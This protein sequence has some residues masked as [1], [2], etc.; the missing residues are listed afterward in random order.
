MLTTFRNSLFVLVT[1][2][3][4][5][6]GSNANDWRA[7][8]VGRVVA[9]ADVHGAYDAMVETL[10]NVGILD[11]QLAW[12][13]GDAYL[14]IVGDLLDRGPRSRDALDLLMRLENEAE[15]AGG[16]VQVLIGNHESMNLIGDLRYVSK[17]EY[18]AFADEETKEQRDYWLRAWES[19]VGGSRLD[20]RRR[21][22]NSFP[23]GFFAL[24]KAFSPE[25]VYGKWL[26]QKNVVAVVNRTAFVHGGLPPEVADLGLEGVNG[27]LKQDLVD[28][29]NAVSILTKAKVLLPMDAFYDHEEIVQ[30]YL[31]PLDT[32][33]EVL[34]AMAT[35]KRLGD[36]AVLH[37]DGPL[38]YRGNIACS[39]IIEEH[40]LQASLD[41]IGA[42][43][44]VVGHTP[45]PTRKVLQRF[46]GRVIEVDTGMLNTYYKGSGN[47]LVM[48]GDEL[49]VFNQ[50]GTDAYAPI[51]HPR[52]VG[53]RPGNLSADALQQLLATGE[54]ISRAKEDKAGR[55]LVQVSDNTHTVSAI[56][57]KR[58]GKGF[59]PDVAAY[60]LDRLLGLDMVPVTALRK[61]G[62]TEGSLQFFPDRIKDEAQRSSKGQLGSAQCALP[63][64]WEAMYV[65]DILIYNEGRNLQRML[66]QTHNWSLIL[67]EH[68]S[69]FK[70]SKGRPP[71]LARADVNVSQGWREAL[72]E[73][74]DAVLTERLADVLD[75]RRLK[76]L[77]TR[78]DQLLAE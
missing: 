49:R 73:L 56:F 24:R 44:V 8:G 68:E 43:R 35:V 74:D 1:L 50:A 66:Y 53:V 52:R 71:H 14:V 40:R 70:N 42:D 61:L 5:A 58:G 64:Q 62:K 4:F 3:L 7:D 46:G 59:Y 32:S 54:I 76:A 22:D 34:D 9:I 72:A 16:K 25:G 78:R 41:A 12:V 15:A 29:V 51:P 10:G 27:G 30:K 18:E 17:A 19:R 20:L 67:I 31:P 2:L 6:S 39:E 47:A 55:T 65:F 75:K 21:F 11:E 45:T 36:S 60:R 37:S 69:A 23:K 57:S 38:W 63:L 13:G 77:G 26:L 33:Q 28:Y 48:E